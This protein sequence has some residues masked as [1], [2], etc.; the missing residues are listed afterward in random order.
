VISLL[1]PSRPP[2][3]GHS[4]ISPPPTRSLA[5]ALSLSLTLLSLSNYLSLNLSIAT[6]QRKGISSRPSAATRSP[7]LCTYAQVVERLHTAKACTCLPPA[8]RRGSS[9]SRGGVANSAHSF[10]LCRDLVTYAIA[11]CRRYLVDSLITP[12]ARCGLSQSASE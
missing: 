2:A 6:T 11:A 9:W 10:P 5:R 8:T 7:A 1:P 3:I 4:A 12:F